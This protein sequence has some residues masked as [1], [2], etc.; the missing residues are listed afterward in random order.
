MKKYLLLSVGCLFFI[1]WKT[2]A[3]LDK[4]LFNENVLAKSISLDAVQLQQGMNYIKKVRKTD[5]IY[6]YGNVPQ[7]VIDS[8][9]N[10]RKLE[11]KK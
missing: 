7:T 4:Q 8:V 6:V 1:S 10:V 5:S 2:N 3:T 11:N 9:M